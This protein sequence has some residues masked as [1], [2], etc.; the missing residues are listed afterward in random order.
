M[1]YDMYINI[2]EINNYNILCAVRISACIYILKPKK[3][4]VFQFLLLR[5]LEF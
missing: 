3:V 2:P 5:I 4:I 1:F